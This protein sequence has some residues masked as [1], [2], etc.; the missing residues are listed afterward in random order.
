[1]VRGSCR[2][3]ETRYSNWCAIGP[4]PS[5]GPSG[6]PLEHAAAT[7]NHE[8][9][10]KLLRAGADGGAGWR[11][12]YDKTL[13]HAAAEGGDALVVSLLLREGA[14]ADMEA[15]APGTGHTPLHLA[16]LGG[17]AAAAKALIMA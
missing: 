9:V 13:L 17:K 5:S 2:I 1:C 4:H 14:G 16:V 7:A 11:G 12:C 8:L 15:K 6:A 3:S 10:S